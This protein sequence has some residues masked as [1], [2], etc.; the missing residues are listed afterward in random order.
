M[1]LQDLFES[2]PFLSNS[3][4]MPYYDDLIKADAWHKEYFREKKGLTWKREN[5]DPGEYVAAVSKAKGIPM[6]RLRASRSA[7]TIAKYSKQMKEEGGR[8]FPILTLDYARFPHGTPPG[9]RTQ[10]LSQEGLH[11]AFAAI[12]AGIEKVPV[13]VVKSVD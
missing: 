5:M 12:D 7:E 13:L 4:E 8:K 2:S 6:E 11:R 3:T 10:Y 1:K 9:K